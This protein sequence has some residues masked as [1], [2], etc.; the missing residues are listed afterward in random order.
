MFITFLKKVF[1]WVVTF[2][3]S[4][5]ISYAIFVI[6]QHQLFD[7]LSFFGIHLSRYPAFLLAYAF[8]LAMII[9]PLVKLWLDFH[10]NVRKKIS[11]RFETFDE[12]PKNK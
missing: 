5:I 3:I 7:L 6:F 9:L 1:D 11:E 4:W 2:F 12:R 8:I 10:E